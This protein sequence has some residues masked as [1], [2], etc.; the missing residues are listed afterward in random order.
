MKLNTTAFALGCGI[1]WG[2]SMVIMTWWILLLDGASA[3]PTFIGSIYRGYSITF[4][5]GLIGGV[6]GFVDGLIGGFIFALLYNW[7]TGHVE[8]LHLVRPRESHPAATAP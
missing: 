5:G 4:A 7:L 6:W 1:L 3:D 8:G 2:A